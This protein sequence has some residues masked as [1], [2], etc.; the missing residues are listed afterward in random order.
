MSPYSAANP[1]FDLSLPTPGPAPVAHASCGRSKLDALEL[2]HTMSSAEHRQQTNRMSQKRVRERRKARMQSTEA[3]L[4][5][6]AAQLQDMKARQK[7][8]EARNALLEKV[9]NTQKQRDAPQ[10]ANTVSLPWQDTSLSTHSSDRGP[11]ITITING[12]DQVFTVSDVGQMSPALYADL[13]ATYANKLGSCLLNMRTN[14]DGIASTQLA[15]HLSDLTSLMI[16]MAQGNPKT[17]LKHGLADFYNDQE[18]Q[19]E[20]NPNLCKDVFFVNLL[21]AMDLSESQQQDM[22]YLRRLLFRKMTDTAEQLRNSG[23][24]EL[25]T[26]MQFSSAFYRGIQTSKQHAIAIVHS[27]P[28]FP[29]KGRILQ[30]LASQRGEPPKEALMQSAG[31]DGLQHAANWHQVVEYLQNI[32]AGNL[33]QHVPLMALD[34]VP[35]LLLQK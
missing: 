34:S 14:A 22:M 10:A 18:D 28:Q 24:E 8:L 26:Y 12:Y 27:Y 30:A 9:A 6:T 35:N 7:L 3:Q 20:A 1:A 11:V 17:A 21:A 15:K 16:C 2:S 32:H 25:K 5:E 19:T 4:A 23:A 29:A 33:N 13:Y 31:M